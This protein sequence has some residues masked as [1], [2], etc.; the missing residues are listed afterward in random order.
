M[1]PPNSGTAGACPLVIWEVSVMC[2]PGDPQVPVPSASHAAIHQSKNWH[3]ISRVHSWS[4]R[5]SEAD[6]APQLRCADKGQSFR[7]LQG[8]ERGVQKEDVSHW[9]QGDKVTSHSLNSVSF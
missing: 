8:R 2:S 4:H 9:I 6:A 7:G 3:P 1:V 5:K